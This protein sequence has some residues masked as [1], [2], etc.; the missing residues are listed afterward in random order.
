MAPVSG[1]YT[2]HIEVPAPLAEEKFV[3]EIVAAGPPS[4]LARQPP[5]EPIAEAEVSVETGPLPEYQPVPE[6]EPELA[7]AD[8]TGAVAEV[9]DLVTIR[10]D[11]EADRP[12]RV[13]LSTTENRPNE[14]IVHISEPL[15]KAVL[16]ASVDDE[17]EVVIGHTTKTAV[18]ERIEKGPSSQAHETN[19]QDLRSI[20]RE[21]NFQRASWQPSPQSPPPGPILSLPT[22]GKIGCD[23]GDGAILGEGEEIYCHLSKRDL[24]WRKPEGRAVARDGVLFMDGQQI[25]PQRGAWLQEALRIVQKKVGHA[26]NLNAWIHWYARRNGKLIPVAELRTVVQT[27]AKRAGGTNELTLDDLEL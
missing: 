11:H 16:G 27:R 5:A 19:L 12:I 26:A 21:T 25:H 3:E 10:Y 13:R 17:I 1:V 23:L 24:E 7:P 8:G 4:T 18:V 9:G 14:G 20:F 15:G 6:P 2:R 22:A